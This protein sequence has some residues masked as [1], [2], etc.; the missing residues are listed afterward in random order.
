M[1]RVTRL[2]RSSDVALLRT[3]ASENASCEAAKRKKDVT[4]RLSVGKQ[5][6]NQR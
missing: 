4:A 3:P 5:I 6:P 1:Y 2:S